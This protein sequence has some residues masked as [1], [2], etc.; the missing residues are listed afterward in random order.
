MM[1]AVDRHR[2]VRVGK[3]VA[4]DKS[5]DEEDDDHDEDDDS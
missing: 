3:H 4:S 5:D 1:Q 2:D